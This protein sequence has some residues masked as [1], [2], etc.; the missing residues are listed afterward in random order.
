MCANDRLG[1]PMKKANSRTV[2]CNDD[3]VACNMIRERK[4]SNDRENNDVVDIMIMH[5]KLLKKPQYRMRKRS[6]EA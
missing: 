2:W 3:L 4:N 1:M 5:S 6:E